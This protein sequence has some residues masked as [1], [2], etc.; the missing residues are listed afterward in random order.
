MG[1][2]V[3]S[4]PTRPCPWA[5]R[6]GRMRKRGWLAQGRGD[7]GRRFFVGRASPHDTNRSRSHSTTK[8]TNDTNQR[9]PQADRRAEATGR[10]VGWGL[11]HRFL[12]PKET[13]EHE[14]GDTCTIG[15]HPFPVGHG[16]V[17][18]AH[19]P[20][21]NQ[22]LSVAFIAWRDTSGEGG[23]K[24]TRRCVR[25]RVWLGWNASTRRPAASLHASRGPLHGFSPCLPAR[26]SLQS[27]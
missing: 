11:P 23:R 9:Q 18:T 26:L 5:E 19:W 14:K 8:Y 27:V 1:C 21:E 4:Q 2:R 16:F 6:N 12:W 24:W 10:A 3:G 20:T 25:N 15:L 13:K 22:Q 17:P 7:A